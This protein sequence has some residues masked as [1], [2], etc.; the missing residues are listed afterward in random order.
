MHYIYIIAKTRGRVSQSIYPVC[1]KVGGIDSWS[2]YTHTL[3]IDTP[4]IYFQKKVSG[5]IGITESQIER[6]DIN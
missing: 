6:W 2:S 4:R 5:N 1:L 3:H